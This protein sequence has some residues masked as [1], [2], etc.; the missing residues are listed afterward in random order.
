MDGALTISD[1]DDCNLEGRSSA[2]VS[3]TGAD[4][5]SSLFILNCTVN[6]SEVFRILFNFAC[7]LTYFFYNKVSMFYENS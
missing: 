2:F 1:N 4:K 6:S 3:G 7:A 5:I